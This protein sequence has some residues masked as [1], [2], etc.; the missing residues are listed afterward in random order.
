MPSWA[1]TPIAI[2]TSGWHH[3][4]RKPL[5]AAEFP[6]IGYDD[7]VRRAQ[8]FGTVAIAGVEGTC[9]YGAGLTRVLQAAA[10]RWPRSAARI[11]PHVAATGKSGPLDACAAG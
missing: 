5:A 1:P 10:S 2:L 6:T 8:S 4:C 3:G 11:G 7:A 9:S